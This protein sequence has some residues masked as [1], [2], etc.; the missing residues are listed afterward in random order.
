MNLTE[1]KEEVIAVI[2]GDEIA[3]IV[4]SACEKRTIKVT[5]A[6]SEG[7]AAFKTRTE[8]KNFTKGLEV[9]EELFSIEDVQVA[10]DLPN[11]LHTVKIILD[12]I[13]DSCKADKIEIYLSGKDN[14][15]DSI[16]LPT[17]YKSSRK[18]TLKPLLLKEIRAFLVRKGAKIVDGQEVDDV[19]CHR[20]WDGYKAKQKIIGVTVDKDACGSAGWLYNRDKMEE[21]E[22]IDGKDVGQLYIDAKNKVR[23]TG[24]KWLYHQICIGDSTD[25][26]NPS[27][28]CGAR[29]GE[30]SSYKLLAPL[31]TDKECWQAIY[32]LY[33]GWYP[34]ITKYIDWEG[35][36]REV[37]VFF[38]LQ[39]YF[40]CA[41][42]RRWADDTIDV[43][44]VLTKMGVK[45]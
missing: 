4:A 31:K 1:E 43:K 12:N 42:M 38:I 7:V 9:P 45:F 24:R 22:F 19:V 5:N 18:D 28:I 21:P 3:F 44:E 23:G 15:R 27:E 25:C 6:L 16:P 26:Y 32:D 34:D 29:F 40:D 33:K 37:D 41:R 20:M 14:F 30:K 8:F 35:T 39:M 17:Q 11:A 36:E 2:D 13:K 10:D